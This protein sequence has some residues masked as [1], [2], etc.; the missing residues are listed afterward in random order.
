MNKKEM[1]QVDK[2]KKN[3]KVLLISI[4]IICLVAIDQITKFFIVGYEKNIINDFLKICIVQNYGGAF[5][6][7]QTGTMT[8]IITNV[9]VIGIIIRFM[10]MQEKQIDK[11]TY[12]ALS[13]IIA[14]AIANLIDK[15]FKGYVVE[16]IVIKSL[17]FNFADILIVLGW[18]L[19][20]LF[21]ATYTYKIKNKK[22]D[23]VE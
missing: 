11:R 12:F 8:F 14:G 22:G 19:L 2:I 4:F 9:I 6:V 21:F 20:A 23:K 15:L 16:F 17:A 13:L 7:G 1:I 10:N 5:G 18:I 3:K